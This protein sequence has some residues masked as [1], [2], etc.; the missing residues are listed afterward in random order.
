MPR[1]IPNSALKE[2][3]LPYLYSVSICLD[4]V[5]RIFRMSESYGNTRVA[6]TRVRDNPY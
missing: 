5:N 3:Q 6:P 2:V 4:N 1:S